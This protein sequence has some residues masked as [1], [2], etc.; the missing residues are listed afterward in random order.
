MPEADSV[1][2]LATIRFAPVEAHANP[3]V[4]LD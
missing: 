3:L 2:L 1:G 4:E